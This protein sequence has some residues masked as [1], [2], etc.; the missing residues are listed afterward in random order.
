[1]E[2]GC[3]ALLDKSQLSAKINI[4][5]PKDTSSID[6]LI[7]RNLTLYHW[8]TNWLWYGPYQPFSRN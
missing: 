3:G 2:N 1:V 5:L 8:S 6:V 4:T 7:D